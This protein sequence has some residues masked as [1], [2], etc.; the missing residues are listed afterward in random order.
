MNRFSNDVGQVAM[1]IRL[2]RYAL[3]TDEEMDCGPMAAALTAPTAA[4][5]LL[6]PR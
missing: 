1:A 6:P 5:I 3:R 2:M 4:P